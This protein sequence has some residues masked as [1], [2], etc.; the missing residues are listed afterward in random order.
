M[1][2]QKGNVVT[3]GLSGKVGGLLVFRQ[4]NGKTVVSKIPEQPKTVSDKQKD[5]RQ[6][7]QSATF[8]AKIAL[9]S[10]ETKELYDAKA[11]KRSGKTAYHVAIAD[12]L[13]APDIH[14]V[15][16]SA[17]TGTAGD[18]IR[19]IAS[20]DFAVVSVHVQIENVDGSIVEEGYAVNSVG[21]LWIYTVTANNESPDGN[22]I[23]VSASDMPGNV[24]T[25]SIEKLDKIDEIN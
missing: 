25:K 12:F 14:D 8:Y 4:V 11:N 7:F 19:I 18:E 2:K 13:N 10:P 15:D 20:D 24:T 6:R 3:Y 5:Q 22:K 17:Y 16:L 1:A 21:N 23:V 9:G